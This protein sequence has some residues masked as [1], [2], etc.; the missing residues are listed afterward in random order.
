MAEGPSNSRFRKICLVAVI[1]AA[2]AWLF[3]F[4]VG[5]PFHVRTNIDEGSHRRG[6]QFYYTLM[7]TASGLVVGGATGLYVADRRRRG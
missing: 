2:V 1:A 5:V 4:C 3:M 6:R 7:V